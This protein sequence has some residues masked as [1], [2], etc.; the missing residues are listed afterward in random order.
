MRI[1]PLAAILGAAVLTVTAAGAAPATAASGHRAKPVAKYTIG[2]PGVLRYGGPYVVMSTGRLGVVST[3]PNAGGPWTRAS[4]PMLTHRAAWASKKDQSV[5]APDVL[6]LPDGK[7]LVV[8]AAVRAGQSYLRCIGTGIGTSPTGPFAPRKHPISC[9]AG[10]AA[11]PMHGVRANNSVI[12]ATVRFF[13]VGPNLELL[14]TYKT[15]HRL[16][17]SGKRYY[18]TIRMARLDPN[19]DGATVLGH[20]HQLTSRTGT[21]E[22]NPVL[23]QRGS[24][25]TLFTSVGG[26]TLCSYH[27]D[28]RSSV[29]PWHWKGTTQHR[30]GGANDTCGTG[31]ADVYSIGGDTWRVFYSARY[32]REKSSFKMYVGVV[33]WPGDVPTVTKLVTPK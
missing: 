25:F 12:D 5:W 10:S 19:T 6:P 26:Y 14:M 30:L 27:T 33:K 18:T 2:D 21:I 1:R 28:W 4:Y 7:Y 15:Q 23:V 16:S 31:D 20:S 32:P 29:H 9:P 13:A 22:E 8:Y 24:T 17:G 3:A 11:D